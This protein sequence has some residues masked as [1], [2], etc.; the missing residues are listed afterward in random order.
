MKLLIYF[1]CLIFTFVSLG[2]NIYVHQC[3][4]A[5]QLSL[6]NKVDTK[7]CPFCEKHHTAD[8]EKG[9][10]CEGEC[11]DSVLKIDQLADKNFNVNQVLFTQLSPAITPLLWIVNFTTATA[12]INNQKNTDYLYSFSDS[13]SPI[14]IQN[15]IFRI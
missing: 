4:E 13:S 12:D 9:G 1:V 8:H 5:T 2:G 11:A 6:Y 7:N 3:K 10:H 14:H 15:C